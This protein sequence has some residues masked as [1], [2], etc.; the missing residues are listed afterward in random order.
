MN[1]TD[2][3]LTE[4]YN[5]ADQCIAM[6]HDEINAI[7]AIGYN[8]GLLDSTATWV[9]G[10][11]ENEIKMQF[12]LP[13]YYIF[14]EEGR[15]P[16]RRREDPEKVYQQILKWVKAKGIV[17]KP[18]NGQ[19][20][21]TQEEIARAIYNKIH[22]A[23]YYGYNQQGKHP[24]QTTKQRMESANIKQKAADIIAKKLNSEIHA[25]IMDFANLNK[26]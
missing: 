13:D 3:D 10:D 19:K 17:G 25:E 15:P 18:K 20:P 16:S 7:Q 2:L 1:I 24:L 11:T 8:R 9:Q 23:G 14:V 22:R 12:T 4:L 5:L 26:R 21:P 6:Y